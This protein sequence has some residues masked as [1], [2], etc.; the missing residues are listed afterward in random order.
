MRKIFLFYIFLYFNSLFT[1][2]DAFPDPGG[3][4]GTLRQAGRGPHP[5][6]VPE[7]LDPVFA[8]TSPKRSFNLGLFS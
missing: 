7:I 3:Q 4:R 6:P 8:K 5:L 1:E 2:A